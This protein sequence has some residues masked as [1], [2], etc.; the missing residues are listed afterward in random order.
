MTTTS[1]VVIVR[2]FGLGKRSQESEVTGTKCS[3]GFEAR[4][5]ETKV[6]GV[7]RVHKRLKVSV[8]WK[9]KGI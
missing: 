9:N 8:T 7:G 5:G 4:E 3:G 6:E 2:L 1:L